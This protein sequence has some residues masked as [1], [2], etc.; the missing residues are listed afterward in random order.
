VCIGALPV[1]HA[2]GAPLLP[3]MKITLLINCARCGGTHTD[4]EFKPLARPIMAAEDLLDCMGKPYDI[5]YTHWAP[6][7][8]NGE[9]IIL[10]VSA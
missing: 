4:V 7:P 2:G 6:C 1:G 3:K 9:P 8:T 10:Y 5:I